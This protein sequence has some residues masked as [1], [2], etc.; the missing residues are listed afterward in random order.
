LCDDFCCWS[1]FSLFFFGRQLECE[2]HPEEDNRNRSHAPSAEL[3]PSL[4]EQFQRRYAPFIVAELTLLLSPCTVI[5]NCNIYASI[6][7]EAAL[8]TLPLLLY[9]SQNCWTWN[10]MIYFACFDKNIWLFDAGS[11]A[12][13]RVKAAAT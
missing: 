13:P 6:C 11:Q 4:Q 8:H 2:G 5:Q 10:I 12:P 7:G 3:A 9:C 1:F